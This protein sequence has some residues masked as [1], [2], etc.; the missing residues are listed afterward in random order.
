MMD[1]LRLAVFDLDGTL[2]DSASSIVEGITAC[3]KACRFPELDPEQARR[4][5]GLPW[6]QSMQVLLPGSGERE[7]GMI[8]AYYD[9]VAAGRRAPPPRREPAFPGACETL[10]ALADAGVLLA[11][12]TSRGNHRV[13]DILSAC[14][15]AGHFL[16]VKTVDHGPGKPNPFL[17]LQAMAEAGVSGDQTVMVGDTTYDILMARNA[18]TAAVGVDWGVHPP[19]ELEAAGANRV[20][21]RF[22]EIPPLVHELT[23]G[24]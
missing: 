4:V 3:W 16:T 6:D 10:T 24:R 22:E 7:L 5:I 18:R 15:I 11:I 13:H 21:T 19:H 2:I 17:L 12:V 8:R 14:G 23:G 9:D 20:V 1:R